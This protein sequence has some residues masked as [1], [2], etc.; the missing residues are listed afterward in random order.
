MPNSPPA[1]ADPLPLFKQAF[2]DDD[3]VAFTELLTRFPEMKARIND[4]V[5]PFDSPLVTCVKSRDML[6]VLLAAG[7]DINARSRWW[8]GGFGLLDSATPDLAAYAIQRGAVV[9]AHAAARLGMVAELR[10][11]VA[12]DPALVHAR[13]GDGQTPLHFAGTVEIADYLIQQGAKIDA[14]DID[15]ESTPAQ[16]MVRDRQEVARYLVSRGCRTDLLMACAL[17]DEKRVREHLDTNPRCIRMNVSTDYFPKENPHSGGT[18][19]TWT[20]GQNKSAHAIAREFG[21]ERLFA[22]LLERSP[23]ELK[24]VVACEVGD[25]GLFDQIM[26]QHPGLVRALPDSDRQRLAHA[27]RDENLRA[28]ELMLS[29]GWPTDVRGQ[30]GATPLHWAAFHGNKQ[31]TATIL[32]YHPPLECTD[33]DFHATPLGWA[34]HGS[35]HGWRCRTGDYAGTVEVLLQAG[36]KIPETVKGTEAVKE[37]VRRFGAGR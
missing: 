7:A 31:M 12:A 6:D 34:T 36:A 24:L 14:R 23:G 21:H 27:A 28:V 16:Y 18:I 35:E 25:Q 2:M 20:L 9:D 17:G 32:R 13:G 33:S 4:P 5:G 8:A 10:R 1:Q 22:L 26:A 30:H 11:L 29:A 3:A 19:Y 15:H 37:V